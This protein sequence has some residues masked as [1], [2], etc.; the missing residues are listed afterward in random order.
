MKNIMLIIVLLFCVPFHCWPEYSQ[1]IEGTSIIETK[2]TLPIGI[3]HISHYPSQDAKRLS[4]MYEIKAMGFDYIH[5]PLDTGDKPTIDLAKKLGLGVHVEY[6]NND[7]EAIVEA[8]GFFD[9]DSPVFAHTPGDDVDIQNTVA[10]YKIKEASY[11]AMHPDLL[12]LASVAYT[13]N[14]FNYAGLSDKTGQQSY[15]IPDESIAAT[16]Y[17]FRRARQAVDQ[18]GGVFVAHVQSMKWAGKRYPTPQEVE[19]MS[20]CAINLGADEILYYAYFDYTGSRA[21]NTDLG[22]QPT[23]RMAIKNFILK[24]RQYQHYFLNGVRTETPTSSGSIAKWA[25]N[26]KTLTVTINHNTKTVVILEA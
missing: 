4:D 8:L 13:K 26:G 20:W 21:T 19:V 5:A 23:I 6:N 11:K 25:L 17:A 24:V 14:I 16:P 15:P 12:T 3:Y 22:A 10:G 9:K 7:K 2:D 18:K 1:K